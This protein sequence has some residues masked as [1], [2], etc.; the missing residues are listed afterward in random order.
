MNHLDQTA[1]I[2]LKSVF[3]ESFYQ[4]KNNYL[5]FLP[6]IAIG[7]VL[8]IVSGL[9]PLQWMENFGSLLIF[10]PVNMVIVFWSMAA[11][12]LLVADRVSGVNL[13]W[14]EAFSRTAR[15]LWRFICALVLYLLMA[16]T[17]VFVLIIPGIYISTIFY[18]TGIAVVLEGRD[19]LDSFAISQQAVKGHFFKVFLINALLMCGLFLSS[20]IKLIP[21]LNLLRDG[22]MFFLIAPYFSVL[23][24]VLYFRLKQAKTIPI[25]AVPRTSIRRG[26]GC[27]GFLSAI[28][29]IVI[30]I[31]MIGVLSAG[32]MKYFST[33]QGRVV[34]DN[35]G[36]TF[37]VPLRFPGGVEVERP[38]G[39]LVLETQISGQKPFEVSY[40]LTSL[41]IHKTVY[42]QMDVLEMK[43]LS[44]SPGDS[45][46][47]GSIGEKLVQIYAQ[48][49]GD[50][51]FLGE[52][53]KISADVVFVN[54][55]D[56][57]Q[58]V[59]RKD[60]ARGS[61]LDQTTV[62]MFTFYD[63][64]VLVFMYGFTY[65]P[66]LDDTQKDSSYEEWSRGRFEDIRPILE[67]IQF[68]QLRKE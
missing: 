39:H 45:I 4:L 60:P 65:Q 35:I 43:S 30:S 21:V 50:Q 22:L 26:I 40:G 38:R 7:S 59:M 57:G 17:G 9:L 54:G 31:I 55:R 13:R 24:V 53:Q 47:D 66:M 52:F 1:G 5:V 64:Y 19:Y 48:Q 28:G 36:K 62:L 11:L 16:V 56:W 15:V 18:F 3:V 25:L 32:V 2:S 44:L 12:I 63:R 6:V 49:S 14:S 37:S 58:Y 23:G 29:L 10:G 27:L 67:A 46:E 41:D 61:P 51:N 20:S 33:N 42:S 8:G 68:P 34:W